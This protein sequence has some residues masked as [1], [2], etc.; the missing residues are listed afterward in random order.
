MSRLFA[1]LGSAFLAPPP[2]GAMPDVARER[3]DATLRRGGAAPGVAILC[4]P[5][6]ALVAGGAAA[7]VLAARARSS[8]ALVAV[9]GAEPSTRAPAI[10]PARRLA[11]TLTARGHDAAATG[12][13]AIVKLGA[14]LGE[15]AAE[16]VRA[17]AA[18]GDVP[19]VTVLAGPRDEA[20][21]AVLRSQDLVLVAIADGSDPAVGDLAVDGL[22]PLGVPAAAIE[23]PP[24]PAPV[25][26]LAASGVAVVPPLRSAVEGGLEG[27]R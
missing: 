3:A 21:D 12:R 20:A 16:A 6:D 1:R 2:R 18:A 26:A 4:R 14:D 10:A 15:A 27:L 11:A 9:W 13:L 23:V 25:R 8:H 5:N 7:I 19:A 17:G 22:S 24:T